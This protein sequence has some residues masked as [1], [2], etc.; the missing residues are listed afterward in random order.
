MIGMFEVWWRFAG[1]T[2]V[3]ALL[4]I[5]GLIRLA[6]M[7]ERRKAYRDVLGAMAPGTLLID[8]SGRGREL[9]VVRLPDDTPSGPGVIG[10]SP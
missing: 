3:A 9:I 1:P 6:L 5:H 8:R 7:R 2:S 10:G 4:S